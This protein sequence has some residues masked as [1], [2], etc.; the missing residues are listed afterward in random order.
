MNKNLIGHLD[1]ILTLR[2]LAI[3]ASIWEADRAGDSLYGS[4]IADLRYLRRSTASNMV[5]RLS[6]NTA[7]GMGLITPELD[8]RNRR[9]KFARTSQHPKKLTEAI[10][11]EHRAYTQR[12]KQL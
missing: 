3:L 8:P 10:A 1:G 9:R 11:R 12:E 4:D 2:Q 5:A 7:N 6:D